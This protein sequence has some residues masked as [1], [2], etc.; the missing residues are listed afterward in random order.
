M[1]MID[2]LNSIY[3]VHELDSNFNFKCNVYIKLFK[4]NQ[5]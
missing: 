1:F 5:S 3:K 4:Y 2:D